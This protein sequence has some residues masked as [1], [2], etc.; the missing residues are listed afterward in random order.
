M[1]ETDTIMAEKLR[2]GILF[3]GRSAEHEVSLQS[4]KS[5]IKA[6]DTDKYEIILIGI[7]K[8]GRFFLCENSHF[9]NNADIHSIFNH[10]PDDEPIIFIPDNGKGR[11]VR[12]S[13]KKTAAEID[14][15]FPVLHGP[16]GEDGTIQGYLKLCCIP[17]VGADVLGSS[18][19][20][21]KDVMKRLFRESGI[22]TPSFLVFH[23]KERSSISFEHIKKYFRLP[24]FIKPANLGSSV[25]IT[26]VKDEDMLKD[27]L[28]NAFQYD[29]KI[30][31]EEAI[32]GREIEC[33]VLGNNN[34]VAS[35]P[36]E[37]IPHHSFYSYEAKYINSKGVELVIPANLSS[38]ITE[39]VK[40]LAIRSFKALC[41]SGMARV[42]FFL[43]CDD[44]L[45]VNEINTIP[46][47][48]TISM[49]PKL[50]EASG[51]SFS[52]LIDRLVE[53][54]LERFNDES[55]LHTSY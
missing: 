15:I 20:M 21:D 50:W 31:I 27:A 54:A 19:S 28:S 42:D 3:G 32:E 10:G 35:L 11:I 38:S 13:D 47:F 26:R 53:L 51:I 12:I 43:R 22:P 6:T 18:L 16:F 37:I 55:Q 49:Y 24:F 46:G 45:L 17:F 9:L 52:E 2:L 34:P 40:E 8:N 39:Q 5:I 23:S 1:E 25:G 33:S 4:A 30:I 29:N 44:E 14:V 36:G 41:C 48:T 7:E